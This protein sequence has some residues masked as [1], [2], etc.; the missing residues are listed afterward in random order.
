MLHPKASQSRQDPIGTCQHLI[1]HTLL[2]RFQQQLSNR[3]AHDGGHVRNMDTKNT[4]VFPI[5][6][7]KALSAS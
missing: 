6:L 4:N 1:F 7:V 2:G 3:C 5:S